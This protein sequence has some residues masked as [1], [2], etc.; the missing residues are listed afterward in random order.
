M[1]GKECVL[2][3]FYTIAPQIVAHSFEVMGLA[4]MT[5]NTKHFSI[6]KLAAD[7]EMYS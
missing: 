4:E 2:A 5:S 7:G 3:E 1:C 6:E